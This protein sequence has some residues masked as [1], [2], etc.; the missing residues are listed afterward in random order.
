M[1][2]PEAPLPVQVLPPVVVAA[3]NADG[4]VQRGARGGH[5]AALQWREIPIGEDLTAGI[6]AFSP[7]LPG[8]CIVANRLDAEVQKLVAHIGS[9]K[10]KTTKTSKACVTTLY[11]CVYERRWPECG[12]SIQVKAKSS[13]TGEIT[14]Q[15]R[16]TSL[17][18]DHDWASEK[19][20][21]GAG[22]AMPI[23]DRIRAVQAE[24]LHVTPKVMRHKLLDEI[25]AGTL[26][27]GTWCFVC[28][29]F[30]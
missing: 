1:E 12:A 19:K 30:L 21:P 3:G 4:G 27:V 22:L 2:L 25:E 28:D 26:Q 9:M 11:R 24:N 17:E 16:C 20:A 6:N 15:L 13:Q 23:K 14:W 10:V 5:R 8:P 18:H 7:G 29:A